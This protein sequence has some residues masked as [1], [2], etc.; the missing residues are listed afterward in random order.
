MHRHKTGALIRASVRLGA[1]CGP[2]V[3]ARRLEQLDAYAACI[4]LA[5]QVRDDILDVE[6]DTKTLGKAQG[7]DVAMNKPTYPS[8]LGLAAAK[9][10]AEEL[11]A[12]AI[13]ELAGFDARADGLRALSAFIVNRPH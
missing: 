11:H 12:R 10:K 4:G 2:D 7:A 6:A 13:D 9:Q 8:P 1:L 3:D 5:F